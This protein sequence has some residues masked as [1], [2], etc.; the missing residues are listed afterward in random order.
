MN[1]SLDIDPE[2]LMRE[3]MRYL[4][5]IDVFRAELCEPTW[6]AELAPSGGAGLF[7][8]AG[9]AKSPKAPGA[10]RNS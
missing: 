2:V 9:R 5:A 6:L 10:K 7:S 4:A 3:V 1:R 8:P